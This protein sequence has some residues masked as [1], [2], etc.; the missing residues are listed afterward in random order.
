MKMSMKKVLKSAL[1]ILVKSET[2]RKLHSTTNT[3]V[4]S[5]FLTLFIDSYIRA[6]GGLLIHWIQCLSLLTDGALGYFF[7]PTS[8]FKSNDK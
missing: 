5:A 1:N 8:S 2:F 7:A 3:S 6:A 4:F